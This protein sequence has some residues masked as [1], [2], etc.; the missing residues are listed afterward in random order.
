VRAWQ[1]VQ[2]QVCYTTGGLLEKHVA[3]F[4]LVSFMVLWS[5]YCS[6]SM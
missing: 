3:D 2:Q 4:I 5:I 1:K 6:V